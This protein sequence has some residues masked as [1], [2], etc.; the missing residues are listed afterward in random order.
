M[1]RDKAAIK[2]SIIF[3]HKTENI[4]QAFFTFLDAYIA[5]VYTAPNTMH[6][7]AITFFEESV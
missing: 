3:T 2:C 4:T 6:F 1:P 7:I 5:Y